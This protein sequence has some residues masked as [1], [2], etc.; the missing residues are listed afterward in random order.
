MTLHYASS[1]TAGYLP[2]VLTVPA[3]GDTVPDDLVR[4]VVKVKVA[5]KEYQVDLPAEPNRTAEI[6]WDGLDH[7]GRP[8]TGPVG[9]Q[10]EIGFVYYGVYFGPG[11]DGQ[12]FG[13]A[14]LSSLTIPTRQEVILWQKVQ[15]PIIRGMGTL[16][17]GW[18]IS[19]HHQVSPLDPS[20]IFKGDGTISRNNAM[21]I[22]TYAGNGSGGYGGDGG[23]ATEAA[24]GYRFHGIDTDAAGNLYIV[25]GELIGWQ[26]FSSGVRKV[27]ANGIITRDVSFLRHP[28]GVAV[29]DQ[30]NIYLAEHTLSIV[31][32]FD[33][34]GVK[35][36]YAGIYNRPGY[37]GDGIP[38][39]QARLNYT[40]G[41][42][43]DAE[44]NLYIADKYNHRIRKVDPSGI[45]TTVVGNGKGGNSGDG[46]PAT[47]ATL[48]YPSEIAVDK[49]GNLYITAGRTVRMVDAS[50]IITTVA[51]NGDWLVSGDGGPATEAGLGSTNGLD[52][53]ALGNLYIVSSETHRV[54]KV[55]TNGIITT[56]AGS[57]PAGWEN[58]GF[59]GDGG[60]A[61]R[62]RMN[63]PD[64]VAVDAAGNIFVADDGNRRIRIVSPP[65]ARLQGVM[66]ASDMAFTED[67]GVGYIM[68]PAGRHLKTVDLDT[69]VSLYEFGYDGDNNLIS[70]TDQFGNPITIEWENG[71]PTAIISADG[72]TTGLTVDPVTR[73]LTDITYPDGSVYTFDYTPDGLELT[74]TQPELNQFGHIFDQTG[75]IT[76]FTDDE[77][78]HW[79]FSR[80]VLDDGD[81]WHETLTGE[82]DR[83]TY[84]ERQLSTGAYSSTITSPAG[85]E[86]QYERSADGLLE[87][88]SLP[89]GMEQEYT[90]DVDAEYKYKYVK[91]MIERTPL[92]LQRVTQ[93]TKTYSDAN[94]DGV[95]DLII[96]QIAVNGKT[97]S[98]VHDTPAS[99]RSLTSPEGRSMT[100]LYD[101]A[102]LLPIR[103][104][105]PELHDT[106]FEFDTRGRIETITTDIRQT[107]FDYV[108]DQNG[109]QITV[110]DPEKSQTIYEFDALDRLRLIQRP[111]GSSV[112]FDYDDNGNMELLINPAGIK[113][114][115]D[116]TQVNLKEFYHPPLSGSY[117][118]VYD[119]DRRLK[120]T[121]FPSGRRI[122][123]VYEDGRL[124]LIDLPLPE[125]DIDL[126]Y[127]ACGPNLESLVKGG[128]GIS[129]GYDGSLLTS[130]NASGTLEQSLVYT[131]D[132]DFRIETFQYAGQ[133]EGYEYDNDNLLTA[134]GRFSITRNINNG[135][136]E[137]V[138]ADDLN[139]TPGFNS[140]GELDAEAY[141]VNGINVASWSVTRRDGAGRILEKTE[142]V[143]GATSIYEYMYD[144]AG[145]LRTVTKNGGLVEEY[146][147]DPNGTGTR[148]Y[149]MNALRGMADRVYD[150]SDEDHLLIAGETS[151]QNDVDGFLT[152]KTDGSDVTNYTYS[153]RG[154]LLSVNLPDGRTIEYIHDPLGRRIAKK[155]DGVFIE[156]YLWQS[157][158]RLLA[159]YD[160]S[161][162]LLLRFEYA[163]SRVPVAVNAEGVTYYLTYDQVGSLRVVADVGGN[164]IKKIEYDAFGNV[165][166]DTNASFDILFGFAGGLHDQD[167]GLVRFGYRDYDPDIGRWTAKDPIGFAGGDTDLYGYVLSDPVNSYDQW[168]LAPSW[169]GIAG[170]AAATTGLILFGAGVIGPKP[171]I[172]VGLGLIAL[173]GA[174]KVWDWTSSPMEAIEKGKEWSTPLEE[175]MKENEK[176]MEKL[177]DKSKT[178]P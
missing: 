130:E 140:Y 4:I 129:F 83:T 61:T 161:D 32:K 127:R 148:V 122:T 101:P 78:G 144:P 37:N 150:Y 45:I 52:V 57:G 96:E 134:A 73:H 108:D 175:Q 124:E 43:V 30:G 21:V 62:A 16:A 19:S 151:Y 178:C 137:A 9:A 64:D 112:D 131:Y 11:S 172:P 95:P 7:L 104:Q 5:G 168:G 170:E 60:A 28:H 135:L 106:I 65:A 92:G 2:G 166:E 97:A 39:T 55:D 109:H 143:D 47:K 94:A 116:Y 49:A 56:I 33:T 1:R 152:T 50:G 121:Y 128:E 71:V 70:I 91:K 67:T 24:L 123:N 146:Q 160:G 90:Y 176:L 86:T 167:I 177:N 59:S 87:T 63:N 27:D 114:G 20:L 153:S 88:L 74:K 149:E 126:G 162:N 36:T 12:A 99:R 136:P 142:T 100:A 147:Y 8:V 173:G 145:R 66:G 14:G 18:S 125:A 107:V 164:V 54:R 35:T 117:R 81:V 6:Q 75:R 76:D 169:V 80:T 141:T 69:G 102:T 120:E 53:D 23:P 29:D 156:K 158:T 154:E 157:L 10:V 34:N 17:E 22:N 115:F 77:G 110:T 42:D 82:G 15:V 46:G 3:S 25:Y 105:I 98:I 58:G 159:V 48:T 163:D 118:Y 165:I 79:Q 133:I 171:L 111:D 44:G 68:S 13:R 113:H 103:M 174:L 85:A 132:N 38:A 93:K 41:L 84:L 31:Y 51:G 138:T 155:V 89:C 139:L 40:W 26:N 119:K 72:I